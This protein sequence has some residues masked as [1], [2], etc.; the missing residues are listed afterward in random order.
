[1][2]RRGMFRADPKINLQIAVVEDDRSVRKALGRLLGSFG[3]QVEAFASAR[4]LLQA[5][6]D[7]TPDCLVLDLHMPEI[8][9]LQLQARLAVLGWHLPI[10]IITGSGS[11]AECGKAMAAGAVAL[12]GKPFVDHELLSAISL[13]TEHRAPRRSQRTDLH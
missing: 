6:N 13:A 2:K 9:G 3:M 8:N 10:I 11:P 12:L 1:M 7:Y 5:L 4:E